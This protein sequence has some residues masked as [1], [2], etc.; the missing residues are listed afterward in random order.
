MN[1]TEALTAMRYGEIVRSG[2]F[3]YKMREGRLLFFNEIGLR[4]WLAVNDTNQFASLQFEKYKGDSYG[5][6]NDT[7]RV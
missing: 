4:C 1:W 7:A 6:N 2:V 3:L 5:K